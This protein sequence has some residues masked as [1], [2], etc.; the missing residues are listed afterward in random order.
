MLKL[1]QRDVEAYNV[2]YRVSFNF[3][4]KGFRGVI[5]ARYKADSRASRNR[6]KRP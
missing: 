3:G 6:E 2:K 5:D 4:A 1:P